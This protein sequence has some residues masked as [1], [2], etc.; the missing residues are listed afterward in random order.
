VRKRTAL[1]G[2]RMTPDGLSVIGQ[3][4]QLATDDKK[5]EMGVVEAPTMVRSPNG[6]VMFY[7]A[8]YYGWNAED[9]LSPYSMGYA[10]CKGPL[11]PCTDAKENPILHSFRDKEA[12][13]ISGP[14]HQSIFNVGS[15]TFVTFHAWAA[16]AKCLK[17][18]DERYMYVAPVIWKDGKPNLGVSLRAQ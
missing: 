18:E 10:T 15:R 1:W 14:G 6:Y 11:G 3:P 16:T 2:Q 7:S 8:G 13:C 17:A 4:I 12:G 5:W 9:R